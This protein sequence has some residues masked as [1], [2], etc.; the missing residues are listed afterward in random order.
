MKSLPLLSRYATLVA[1][2][3]FSGTAF[4][5]HGAANEPLYDMSQ[6]REFDGIVT[7]VFWRNPHARFRFRVV[8]GE[9]DGQIWEVETNPVGILMR[10]GFTPDLI[11]VGS[12]IKV[13]GVVSRR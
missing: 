13:A 12:E 8:G 7:D 10:T 4:A 1:V 3:A 9:E 5:H 2:T 11:P 6:V